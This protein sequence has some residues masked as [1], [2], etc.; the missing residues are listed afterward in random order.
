MEKITIE[1]DS[2]NNNYS[3]EVVKNQFFIQSIQNYANDLLSV[4]KFLT[5]NEVFKMLG[6]AQKEFGAKAGWAEGDVIDF[7]VKELTNSL[8][9]TFDVTTSNVF[10]PSN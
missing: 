1:F 10:Q 4:Q 7:G 9:I 6:F 2:R 3:D 5:L 8:K